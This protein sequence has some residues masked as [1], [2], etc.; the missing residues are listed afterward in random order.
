MS[1]ARS[2]V[3]W[4]VLISQVGEIVHTIDIVPNVLLWEVGHWL[5]WRLDETNLW[6]GG[7]LSAG[8]LWV[9]ELQVLVRRGCS[10][11]SQVN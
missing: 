9:D 5:Q 3:T 10:D 7:G 6:L 2:A 8:S 1:P 4:D 11:K